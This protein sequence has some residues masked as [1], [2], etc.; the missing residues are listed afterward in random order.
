MLVRKASNSVWLSVR[1][2][3]GPPGR[4]SSKSDAAS[5]RT[6]AAALPSSL[7]EMSQLPVEWLV[8]E[9]D[10]DDLAVLDVDDRLAVLREAVTRLAV[11]ERERLVEAI[12]ISAAD[13]AR[14]ALVEVAA[15][16]EVA[17]GQG[18][19]RLR[20]CELVERE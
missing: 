11:L 5:I 6:S 18:E 12:D 8:A 7:S 20:A 13:A 10:V 15:Q 19:D 14:L 4:T 9:H 1:R 16:A 3:Q 2:R 17:V